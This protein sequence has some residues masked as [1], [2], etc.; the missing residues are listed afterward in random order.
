MAFSRLQIWNMA[1]AQVPAKRVDTIDEASIEREACSDAYEIALQKLLEGSDYDF[2][3]VRAPLAVAVNDRPAEWPYAYAL[4]AD[5]AK[6]LYLLPYDSAEAGNAVYSWVGRARGFEGRTPMRIAGNRLYARIENAV[7]EYVS[8]A[9]PESRFTA[10]F[11]DALAKELA[12]IIV[13]PINKDKRRQGDLIRIAEVARQRAE[14]ENMNRDR[15][16]T[17]DFVPDILLA[18]EGLGDYL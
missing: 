8:N 3:T 10:K 17:R 12:S 14:A 6:P 11:A 1:L 2:A 4:P 9:P 15:E 5:L 7:L 16:S 13:M 18:R